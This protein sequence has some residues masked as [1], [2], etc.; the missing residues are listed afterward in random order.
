M[1]KVA[2]NGE[3]VIG[4]KAP[5]R[6]GR[7]RGAAFQDNRRVWDDANTSRYQDNQPSW[8]EEKPK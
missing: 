2:I 7:T 1:E 3:I 8:E 6:E 4:R 5:Q